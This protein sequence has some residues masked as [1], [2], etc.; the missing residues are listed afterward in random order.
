MLL[1]L[2]KY[3]NVFYKLSLS[4]PDLKIAPPLLELILRGSC[5]Y[6]LVFYQKN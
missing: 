2:Q 3:E 5:K 6:A 4:S 1:Y